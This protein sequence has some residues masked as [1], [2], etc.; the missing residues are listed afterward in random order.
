[1][2]IFLTG[3]TG[4][5]GRHLVRELGAA[6]HQ[7]VALVRTYE[8]A[9]ALPHGV[10]MVPGDVTKPDSYRSVLGRCDAALHVAAAWSVGANTRQRAW[11]QAI[12]VDGT[13][14]VLAAALAAGV[15]RVVHVSSASVY[16]H[17]DRPVPEGQGLVGNRLQTEYQRSKWAGHAHAADLAAEGAPIVIA[18]PGV[19]FGPGDASLTGQW[20]TRLQAGRL[21]WAPGAEC[22]RN[23]AHVA[24]VARGLRLALEHGQLGATY[25]LGGE[26]LRVRD[27]L[28]SA[29]RHF[30]RP[31]PRL[32]VSSVWA[33]RLA[34]LWGDR[35][36]AQAERWRPWAGVSYQ[37]DTALTCQVLGWAPRS[38]DESLGEVGR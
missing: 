26:R 22:V 32:W 38:V 14:A 31:G 3:A 1:M 29:A 36:P 20:L 12:N 13:R 21:W 11:L 9:R 27:F 7:V 8:R 25:H 33:G 10:R 30:R 19:T 34:R 17:A 4:F 18:V 37:L 35:W 24:D 23:W 16:G 15:G 6:G 28:T 2:R 5:I